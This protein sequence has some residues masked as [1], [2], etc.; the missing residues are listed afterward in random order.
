MK[1]EMF[2]W[3]FPV[4][5]TVHNLEEAIWLPG[6]SQNAGRWHPP[7]GRYEF[8]FAVAVLT[9]LAY[10]LMALSIRQGKQSPATYLFV[11]YAFAMLLNV[12]MPHLISSLFL[13]R[14]SPGLATAFII[15]L[16]VTA[17]TWRLAVRDGFVSEKR[18]L[19]VSLGVV[20]LLLASI[21][22]LFFLGRHLF[23]PSA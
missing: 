16:P 2:R 12:I 15:N 7:V 4:A 21:P 8:W 20:A 23:G 17:L 19:L 10:V 11:G 14:Y 18:C 3:L 6:W 22:G 9:A 1:F 5:I 13:H